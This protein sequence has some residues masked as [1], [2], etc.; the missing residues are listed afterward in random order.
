[1]LFKRSKF[2]R[3]F[4][5]AS[6][7]IAQPVSGDERLR[8]GEDISGDLACLVVMRLGRRRRQAGI[9]GEGRVR[10]PAGIDLP[11][12]R[13][14]PYRLDA[15]AR[16]RRRSVRIP[17]RRASEGPSAVRPNP[18]PTRQ[19]G[20]VRRSARPI[21]AP[22]ISPTRERRSGVA[23]RARMRPSR[24]DRT[25][26]P[27]LTRRAGIEPARPGVRNPFVIRSTRRHGITPS[28][29]TGPSD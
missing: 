28:P 13:L 7:G 27:S 8:P 21:R 24:T 12:R 19:R 10:R 16:V 4:L 22:P 15:P 6:D 20:S 23:H 2:K 9:T 1:M 29:R 25:D 11:E 14:W 5:H 26:R 3:R 18:S 17:A